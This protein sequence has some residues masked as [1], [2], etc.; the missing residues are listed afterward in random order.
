MHPSFLWIIFLTI[1][2]FVPR[3]GFVQEPAHGVWTDVPDPAPAP[4]AMWVD[5]RGAPHVL[6]NLRGHVVLL[7]IWATWCRPCLAEMP[8]FDKLQRRYGDAGLKVIPV[9]LDDAGF[10]R[11]AL[12]YRQARLRHLPLY[13]DPT[14]HM[15]GQLATK[16]IPTTYVINREGHLV[17]LLEGAEDWFSAPI[18]Q[19]IEALLREGTPSERYTAPTP[20]MILDVTP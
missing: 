5:E 19:R 6:Q 1:V 20:Q 15:L 10:A 16:R 8:T 4:N 9:A 18:R 17:A 3:S 12:F 7:N 11:M 2:A 14:G 13:A